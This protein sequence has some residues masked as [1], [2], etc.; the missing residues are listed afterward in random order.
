MNRVAAKFA[1]E[2]FVHFK[3]R[4]ANT[5]P[6]EDERQYRAGRASADDAAGGLGLGNGRAA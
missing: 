5:A 3:E 4:D 1:V 2:I 6:R